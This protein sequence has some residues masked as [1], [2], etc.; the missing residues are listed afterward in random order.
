[1][2]VAASQLVVQL[3][4][5]VS[6]NVDPLDSAVITI[7]KFEGGVRQNVIA[8]RA[9]LEGTIRTLS[10]STMKSVKERIESILKGIEAG[11]NCEVTLDYGALYHQVFNHEP[12][13]NEFMNWMRTEQ[14]AVDERLR[15]RLVECRES[16][17][18]E[19]FGYFL[20]ETPG[21][22]FWLGVDSP[23]GLHHSKLEPKEEAIDRAVSVVTRYLTWKSAQ[24]TLL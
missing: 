13:T 20:R 17:T 2:I 9:R 16:M 3:Q 4:T 23:Y 19:D 1:M 8:E 22:M 11:Y 21:F 15:M 12:L 7:G 14:T 6:R 10:D 24:P 18:G 5:I